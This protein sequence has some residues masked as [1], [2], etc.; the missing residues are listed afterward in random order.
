MQAILVV[1]ITM[2]AWM[3]VGGGEGMYMGLILVW[4]GPFILLLWYARQAIACACARRM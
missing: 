3:V 1:A 2:G 4:A